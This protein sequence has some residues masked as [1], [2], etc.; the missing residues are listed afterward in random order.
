MVFSEE[1]K[2][3]IKSLYL[4]KGYGPWRLMTE[5]TGKGWKGLHCTKSW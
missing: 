4:I 1:H 3:L 2:A 5:L